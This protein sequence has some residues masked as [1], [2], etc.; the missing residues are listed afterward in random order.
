[1][2]STTLVM[3]AIMFIV[4]LHTM[5]HD[6]DVVKYLQRFGYYRVVLLVLVTALVVSML[7]GVS[8]TASGIYTSKVFIVV[9]ATGCT[10]IVCVLAA[11]SRLTH[12]TKGAVVSRL[13]RMDD[14]KSSHKRSVRPYESGGVNHASEEHKEG[15]DE[16]EVDNL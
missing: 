6:E 9:L 16:V 12:F 10:S 2:L 14:A 13:D 8:M 7:V 3:V 11:L 15:N 1:M 4:N 5:V